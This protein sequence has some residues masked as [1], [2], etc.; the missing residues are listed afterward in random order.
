MKRIAIGIRIDR[1]DAE[2]EL[3]RAA[4][5]TQGDLAAIGDQYPEERPMLH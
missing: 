4:H 2:A 1:D 3:P 5:H